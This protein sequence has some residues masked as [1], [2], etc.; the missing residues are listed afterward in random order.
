MTKTSQSSRKS[1]SA[2][3]RRLSVAQLKTLRRSTKRRR[4]DDSDDND[5]SNTWDF[6]APKFCDFGV[7]KTPGMATDKWF[8]RT[9]PTPAPRI[10]KGSR[11]SSLNFMSDGRRGGLVPT[12]RSLSPSRDVAKTDGKL[13][14]DIDLNVGSQSV[15]IEEIEFSNSDEEVEFNKWKQAHAPPESSSS[16]RPTTPSK[17]QGNDDNSA[18]SETYKADTNDQSSSISAISSASEAD[19]GKPSRASAKAKP[20][21][22]VRVGTEKHLT[23]PVELGFMRPTRAVSHRLSAKKREKASQQSIATAIAKSI[24][25]TLAD[26]GS[27][28]LTIPKPFRFHESAKNGGHNTQK[29]A[30]QPKPST[31]NETRLGRQAQG[32][33]ISKLASGCEPEEETAT[34]QADNMEIDSHTPPKRTAKRFKPTVPKTPQF[35][36]SKRVRLEESNADA[37]QAEKTKA[38]RLR[39][40]AVI[41]ALNAMK[42]SPPKPTVIQPFTFRSDAVAERHL[43]KLREEIAKLK[44]EE[45]MLRQFHANPL[46]A[47]PTPKKP[48]RKPS[49]LH[50]SPFNLLTDLRGEAYQRQLLERL[51]ELESRQRER[52]LFKAQPIPPSLDH[53]FVPK[54]SAIPLTAI[55]EILLHTELRG[56]ERREYD[57]DRRERERIREEVLARKR[58]E[59]ERRE[60]EE[61]KLLRKMLVHKAQPVRRY[62]PLAIKPSDR[63]P[64]IPKTP[65]WCVRTRKRLETP[66]TPTH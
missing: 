59:E 49:N 18:A 2:E 38:L 25:R 36:K 23:V 35:A 8:D 40:P 15:K 7:A 47:F 20:A 66:T 16:A 21:A 57:D 61:I 22:A 54:Q 11:T 12:L 4:E 53:P 34:E 6:D 58:L 42:M 51:E 46:P 31:K 65:Q 48:K 64:T 33:S 9:H 10:S 27:S 28:S 43:L 37:E 60:D 32:T 24:N 62:K 56:E 1:Q 55:E 45:K 63:Q 29:Q 19:L 5:S 39:K 17:A 44:A 50:A 13:E 3:K 30:A 14:L 26:E 41:Q 52:T